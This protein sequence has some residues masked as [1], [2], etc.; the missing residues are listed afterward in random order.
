MKP[1]LTVLRS[2]VRV[3]SSETFTAQI[4]R[5]PRCDRK[6]CLMWPEHVLQVPL[7]RVISADCPGCTVSFSLIAID[8][9]TVLDGKEQY[10]AAVVNQLS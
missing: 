9:V 10:A 2:R 8:L 7:H 1:V 5:C 6:L 4:A 3:G